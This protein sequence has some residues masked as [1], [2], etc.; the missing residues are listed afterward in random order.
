M[1]FAPFTPTH[2]ITVLACTATIAMLCWIG[3]RFDAPQQHLRLRVM[4][5]VFGLVWQVINTSYF[6]RPSAFSLGT[7]LP[8]QICDLMGFVAPLAMLTGS[9]YL[10]AVLYFFALGLST[11]AFV[12]PIVRFGP[13]HPEF[14]IFWVSHTII[15][16]YAVIELVVFKYRPS[17]RDLLGAVLTGVGYVAAMLTINHLL[18]DHRANYGFVADIQLAAPTLIDRLGPW[19]LR[20]LWMGVIANLGFFL[21]WAVWPVG[22]RVFGRGHTSQR[23]AATG[24]AS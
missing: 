9:R 13:G 2:G 18:R 7:S 8:L 15:V 24:D 20:V 4:L 19:P 23:P 16:G 5:G 22:R 12:T 14:W 3:R 21:L 6:C 11:Q 17:L 1:S 10:K